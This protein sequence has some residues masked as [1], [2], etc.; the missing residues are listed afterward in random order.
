MARATERNVISENSPIF[1]I[2]ISPLNGTRCPDL[3]TLGTDDG[4]S[5]FAS[6][7]CMEPI[8]AHLVS[9]PGIVTLA[10]LHSFQSLRHLR[11]SLGKFVSK[12]YKFQISS[13]GITISRAIVS[14]FDLRWRTYKSLSTDKAF[15]FNRHMGII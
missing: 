14:W 12:L 3:I 8:I 4:F 1:S 9:F 11:S 10:P 6:Q 15:Y 5:L 2:N 7:P 13:F